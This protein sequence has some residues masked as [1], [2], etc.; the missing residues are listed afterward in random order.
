MSRSAWIAVW[1]LALTLVM[2][3]TSS[4]A[5]PSSGVSSRDLFGVDEEPR[6]APADPQPTELEGDEA[7]A[8]E[9]ERARPRNGLD[10]TGAGRGGVQVRTG[11]SPDEVKRE[12]TAEE[13]AAEEA[14]RRAEEAAAQRETFRSGLI[15]FVGVVLLVLVLGGMA[16]AA[17]LMLAGRS[18][19][20]KSED[21]EE[22]YDHLVQSGP[23]QG[24]PE[25]AAP[26]PAEPSPAEAAAT[27]N[28]EAAEYL[29][30]QPTPAPAPR[31]HPDT[32]ASHVPVRGRGG[33]QV[34][35]GGPA[36]GVEGKPMGHATPILT[37]TATPAPMV[38]SHV[39]DNTPPGYVPPFR[40]GESRPSLSRSPVIPP[41]TSA[42]L[43]G[44]TPRP[45][46]PAQP[47]TAPVP[48]AG[49]PPPADDRPPPPADMEFVSY[50]DPMPPML[51][52][53]SELL[54]HDP[55]SEAT[56]VPA[57]TTA[58]SETP[59]PTANARVTPD[60]QHLARD[61]E[62]GTPAPGGERRVATPPS[63]PWRRTQSTPED[64]DAWED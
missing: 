4:A 1:T 17:Y 52:E 19:S 15:L 50:D 63:M 45:A 11:L 24:A 58:P 57:F 26:A 53:D 51:P 55:T 28:P 22:S 43:P 46:T 61:P 48:G 47:S 30:G 36:Y 49:A 13:L 2:A 7:P 39:P 14:A 54:P 23:T 34:G 3:P 20:K 8:E 59:A 41:S 38:A 60:A 37:P 6:D 25:P 32:P 10:P 21:D 31:R 35:T 40:P 42:S 29:T 16:L 64:E 56:P 44:H 27:S 12:K 18:D 62:S 33:Y 9:P 5:Q